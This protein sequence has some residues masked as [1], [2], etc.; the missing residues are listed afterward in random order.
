[1]KK[2]DGLE[3]KSAGRNKKMRAGDDNYSECFRP[4]YYWMQDWLRLH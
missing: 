3:R 4:G 2:D 1:V